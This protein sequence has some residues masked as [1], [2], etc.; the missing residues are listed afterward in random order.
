MKLT[1]EELEQHIAIVDELVAWV[2]TNIIGCVEVQERGEALL[3]RLRELRDAA[4]RN[5]D[6]SN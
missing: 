5:E 6:G 3:K 2:D 1:R 4:E